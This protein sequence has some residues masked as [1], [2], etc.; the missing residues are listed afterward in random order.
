[1]KRNTLFNIH[2]YLS[3]FFT[4]FLLLMAITGTFYLFGQ[5]GSVEKTLIQD[6]IT[7]NTTI[8]K[9]EQVSQ[10]LKKI[11]ETYSFE[12]IKDR[13]ASIQTRPTTR[14]YFNFV[15]KDEGSFSLYKV[16]P[17]LLSRVIEVHKGH[18][19]GL[20]KSFQKVLGIVLMLIII[21][22]FLM[23]MNIK[24]RVKSFLISTGLG[25]LVL[26]FLFLL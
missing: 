22:G 6:G 23:S 14:D 26:L 25:T 21:T 9:K 2:F 20:L 12:N 8:S 24:K 16:K 18:G 13:G 5:K 10:L 7:F 17:N 15:K 1:M 4:P 19:P 3:S 11:D